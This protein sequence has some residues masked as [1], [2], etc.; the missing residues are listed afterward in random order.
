M[1]RNVCMRGLVYGEST[2]W[3]A[4]AAIILIF[5]FAIWKQLGYNFRYVRNITD[6]RPSCKCADAGKTKMR[7]KN[8]PSNN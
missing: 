5:Y 3:H 1:G 8:P 7:K 2:P 6:V 4:R